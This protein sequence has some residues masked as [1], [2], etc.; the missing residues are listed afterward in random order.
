MKGD[1][2]GGRKK[3]L[4]DCEPE[5]MKEWDWEK[6]RQ[7]DPKKVSRSSGKRVWWRCYKGHSWEAPV[8]RR[9]RGSGCPYCSG[10]LAIP[11]KNDLATV[12]PEL[13]RQIHPH[14]NNGADPS[15]LLPYS[16]RK[17]WW[18]CEKG[19]EWK[20]SVAERSNGKGCP[21]C[22][23]H[24]SIPGE[25]DLTTLCPELALEWDHDKNLPLKVQDIL[26]NS[27]KIVWWKCCKGHSWKARVQ[28]RYLGENCPYCNGRFA[29][30]R[31]TDIKTLYP[32]LMEE[33]D[34]FRN[35]PI[36]PEEISPASNRKIW[37]KC[38]NGHSWQS[39]I[40]VRTT[41]GGG[42]PFCSGNLPA[43]TRLIEL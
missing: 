14:K 43:R 13:C 11:G 18:I 24:R 1:V 42:C 5:L 28:S 32:E 17:F 20:T 39:S 4:E 3:S 12:N 41:K 7:L 2:S 40:Y 23:G 25:R 35:D 26:P 30:P 9:T 34:D 16:N 6:N 15:L 27:F 31:E 10:R 36:R 21:Y 29:I 8:N 38:K 33:W 22:S 19:H 37:W